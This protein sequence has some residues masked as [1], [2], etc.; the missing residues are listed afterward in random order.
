VP[1]LVLVRYG[2]L[3]L[4][5]APV[6]RE[7]ERTLTRNI[8][9]QFAR[10]G[11]SCRLRNDRGHLYVECA[12]TDRAVV[13]LRRTF[14]VTSVSEVTETTSDRDEVRRAALAMADE[15][16]PAGT[17]FAVRARRTGSHPYTSQE[18]AREIGAAI[19]SAWPERGLR[20]DL[21]EPSVEVHVEVRDRR[22]YL[23]R[24]R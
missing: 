22:T 13:L 11:E 3:A 6:R 7:F 14:G 23:Y 2:E 5:S 10:A 24:D 1:G 4:K 12:R 18:L 8:I 19:L 15:A 21:E 16:L 17:S 9:E 20:V